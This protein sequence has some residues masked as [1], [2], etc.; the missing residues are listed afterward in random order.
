MDA[1]LEMLSGTMT[2]EPWKAQAKCRG[3]PRRWFFCASERSEA[4]LRGL[5]ICGGCPVSDEC[6]DYAIANRIDYGIFGG[7]TSLQRKRIRWKRERE[8]QS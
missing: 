5:Q 1:L 4:I 2:K 7:C 6:L 3:L 8:R